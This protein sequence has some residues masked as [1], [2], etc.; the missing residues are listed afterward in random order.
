MSGDWDYA[1]MQ[2]YLRFCCVC[3]SQLA[4]SAG[5]RRKVDIRLFNFRDG[6]HRHVSFYSTFHCGI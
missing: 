4:I 2:D 6:C 1:D 5:I 3:D